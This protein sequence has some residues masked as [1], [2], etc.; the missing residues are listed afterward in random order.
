MKCLLCQKEIKPNETV[1]WVNQVVFDGPND[2][3]ITFLSGSGGLEG[4][5]HP[6]CLQSSGEVTEAIPGQDVVQRSNALA[7]FDL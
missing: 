7:L 1:L 5:M 4:P 2:I 6:K 3:D